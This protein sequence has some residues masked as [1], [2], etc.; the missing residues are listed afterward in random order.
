MHKTS[1]NQQFL[2]VEKIGLEHCELPS[3]DVVMQ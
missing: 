2:L 3:S 1:K